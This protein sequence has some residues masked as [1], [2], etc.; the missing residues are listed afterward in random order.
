MRLITIFSNLKTIITMKK[1]Y[2]IAFAL[3]L[4]LVSCQQEDIATNGMYSDDF[5]ANLKFNTINLVETRASGGNEQEQIS[6][7]TGNANDARG[8]NIGI[9]SV[10]IARPSTGCKRGF[11]FCDFVW[12]PKLHNKDVDIL[13]EKHSEYSSFNIKRDSEGNKFVDLEL[14]EKPTGIDLN[15]LQP[16][17]I[18]EQL[19]GFNFINDK[20][21]ELIVSQGSYPFDSSVGK[22]GGYRIP[23]K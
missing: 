22:F 1:Y 12:F 9:F 7:I 14:A 5:M 4:S 21:N 10:R 8:I 11:G 23:L 15:K 3:L 16:L 13:L 18:E 20:E 2:F 6:Q 19:E 17:V